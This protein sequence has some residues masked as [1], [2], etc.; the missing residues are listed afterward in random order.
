MST[1]SLQRGLSLTEYYHVS[2]L[3]SIPFYRKD[4]SDNREPSGNVTWLSIEL[5]LGNVSNALK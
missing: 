3:K 1:D 4:S 5:E 2:L